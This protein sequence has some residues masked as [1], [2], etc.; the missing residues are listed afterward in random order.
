MNTQNISQAKAESKIRAIEGKQDWM[1][2]SPIAYSIVLTQ[3]KGE[4]ANSYSWGL[5]SAEARGSKSGVWQ[6][7]SACWHWQLLQTGQLLGGDGCSGLSLID[8]EDED[9]D[10]NDNYPLS[11]SN[12]FATHNCKSFTYITVFNNTKPMQYDPNLIERW[13]SQKLSNLPPVISKWQSMTWTQ[14]WGHGLCST[15][16]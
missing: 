12:L 6:Y 5:V 3:S 2:R 4:H 14:M 8:C 16:H 1:Q 9:D 7:K 10:D 15:N 11:C 13:G